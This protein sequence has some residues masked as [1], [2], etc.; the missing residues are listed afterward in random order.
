[1]LLLAF[2]TV[3][4]VTL[5]LDD[6]DGKYAAFGQ[7]LMMSAL[8][9]ALLL[10]RGDVAGQS[11]YIAI[12]K[13]IGTLLPSILFFLRNPTALFLDF[14]YIAIF[15]LDMAYVALLHNKHRELG[16]NSWTRF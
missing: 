11:M 3:L 13:M 5:E 1:M 4:L 6:M 7:N 2:C 9:I 8:F 12:F 15:T 10:R 16:L 14:L